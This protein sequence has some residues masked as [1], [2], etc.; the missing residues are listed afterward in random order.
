MPVAHFYV[1]PLFITVYLF[2]SGT[3]TPPAYRAYP[4]QSS[5][6]IPQFT[7]VPEQKHL[8]GQACA[9]PAMQSKFTDVSVNEYEAGQAC[10]A[11]IPIEEYQAGQ[12][13]LACTSQWTSRVETSAST[14][15]IAS[16]IP[17]IKSSSLLISFLGMPAD[18]YMDRAKVV[19]DHRVP[20]WK[21]AIG[22]GGE[23]SSET[24]RCSLNL[25]CVGPESQEQCHPQAG[26]GG[27][28][29]FE[30]KLCRA[31]LVC[32]K[33][34]CITQ[35]DAFKGELNDVCGGPEG[36]TCEAG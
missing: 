5:A 15:P 21:L 32:K 16:S 19:Y 9:A 12:A 18:L 3:A 1:V 28:C 11:H 14:P 29:D 6:P 4:A 17:T 36:R 8:A 35:A 24:A 10:L 31:E 13:C 26:L 34:K 30:Y 23:Y 2:G 27:A 7:R 33:G 25:R 22:V 20:A